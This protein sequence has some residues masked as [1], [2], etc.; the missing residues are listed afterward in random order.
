MRYFVAP[1]TLSACPAAQGADAMGAPL[2]MVRVA[3]L[4]GH[5]PIELFQEDETGEFMGQ[6]EAGQRQA[7]GGRGQGPGVQPQVAA[8][9]EGQG[10]G[11]QFP[12]GEP[13]GEF[14]RGEFPAL[15]GEGDHKGPGRDLGPETLAFPNS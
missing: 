7:L 14:F 11:F 9:E 2:H 12:P 15:R 1:R 13:G 3:G 5:G 10:A 4:D 8:D 6:G